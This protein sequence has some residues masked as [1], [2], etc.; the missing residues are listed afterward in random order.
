MMPD[1]E[2]SSTTQVTQITPPGTKSASDRVANDTATEAAPGRTPETAW[3]ASTN[4]N[5]SAIERA[6]MTSE[7]GRLGVKRT[8]ALLA[9]A[10]MWVSAQAPLFLMGRLIPLMDWRWWLTVRSWCPG[11]HLFGDRWCC[12]LGLVRHGQSACDCG[13]FAF[14]WC[15]V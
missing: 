7:N 5:V 8:L 4:M 13:Y 12:V 6:D 3:D 10:W 11:L 15:S 1:E 2:K 14:R 9:L